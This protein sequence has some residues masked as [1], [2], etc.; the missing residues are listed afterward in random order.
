[1]IMI[2]MMMMMMMMMTMLMKDDDDDEDDV[3]SEAFRVD[4]CIVYLSPFT[5]ARIK[6]SR[7]LRQDL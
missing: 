5:C 3:P 6:S 2:M 1:M 4:F 7:N